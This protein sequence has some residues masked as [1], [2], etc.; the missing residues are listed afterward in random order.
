MTSPSSN[1]YM[2]VKR[3]LLSR[4]LR[5]VLLIAWATLLLGSVGVLG[6]VAAE[7]Q[8]FGVSQTG[9]FTKT[10]DPTKTTGG[11][12]T[13]VTC[14][15]PYNPSLPA[16]GG[17]CLNPAGVTGGTPGWPRKDNYVYV[18]KIGDDEDAIGL[19]TPDLSSIPFGATL[20]AI[21]FEFQVE[22]EADSGTINY[23]PVATT[24]PMRACLVTSDWAPGDAG[25]WELKPNYDCATQSPTARIKEPEVRKEPDSTG[26]IR[27]RRVVTFGVNLMPMAEEWAK[28]RPIFGIAL[29]TTP[30]SPSDFQVAL[31]PITDFA[32]DAMVTRVSFDAP[33]EDF[34][35]DEF[36]AGTDESV[37]FGDFSGGDVGPVSNGGAF[38]TAAPSVPTEAVLP[39]SNPVTPVWVWAILPIGLAGLTFMARVMTAEVELAAERVGPVGRLMQRRSTAREG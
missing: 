4:R 29:V 34:A 19:V 3:I 28:D 31:R 7:N 15:I 10:Q 27:D 22:N 17:N 2:T 35:L 39:A 36:F 18:S 21:S 11:E 16:G 33:A 8:T 14:N 20:R 37:S 26:T 12:S 13:V 38:S 25:A 24:S 1:E 32:K 5:R 6:A 23:D 9:Y 30:E